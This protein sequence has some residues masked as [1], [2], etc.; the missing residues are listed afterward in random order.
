MEVHEVQ[1]TPDFT[2]NARLS[3]LEVCVVQFVMRKTE[4]RQWRLW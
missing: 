1:R 4:G 2:A 3:R